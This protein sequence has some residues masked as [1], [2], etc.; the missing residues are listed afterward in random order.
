MFEISQSLKANII[1]SKSLELQKYHRKGSRNFSKGNRS[2]RTH[3]LHN[4]NLEPYTL[5]IKNQVKNGSSIN[6]LVHVTKLPSLNPSSSHSLIATR[7]SSSSV[8][9]SHREH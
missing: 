9:R 2:E 7:K 8:I 6:S 5:P 4:A 1:D 3:N